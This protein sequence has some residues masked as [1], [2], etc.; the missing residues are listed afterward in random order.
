MIDGNWSSQENISATS[1]DSFVR[2][3]RS[4]AASNIHIIWIDNSAGPWDVYYARRATDGTWSSTENISRSLGDSF[5]FRDIDVDRSGI[6][7]VVS[8]LDDQ[9]VYVRRETDGTWSSPLKISNSSRSTSDEDLALDADGVVHIV[10]RDS[11]DEDIYY[12][13]RSNDGSWSP[14]QNLSNSPY[15]NGTPHIAVEPG[16]AIDVVWWEMAADIPSSIYYAQRD[17]GGV[18]SSPKI[19]AYPDPYG[20][21][22]LQLAIDQSGARHIL[23]HGH[24]GPYS[25]DIFYLGSKPAEESGNS[26]IAQSILV[27]QT[28][29]NPTLSFLYRLGGVFPNNGNRLSVEVDTGIDSTTLFSTTT[30][31]DR[32]MHRWFDVSAWVGETITLTLKVYQNVSRSYTW[33]YLDEVTLGSAH[34]DVWISASGVAALPGEQVVH[35]LTYGNRGGVDTIGVRISATLPSELSFVDASPSPTATTPALVWEAGDLTAGDGPYIIL[36][37]TTVAPAAVP[38][39]TYITSVNIG[40]ALPEIETH[41]NTASAAT[42]V[43][44]R[45]YLPLVTKENSDW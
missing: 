21:Q 26:L 40:A 43:G 36:V 37:T 31:T 15:Y 9:T 42:F 5:W 13:R 35:A 33:A 29:S 3:I 11:S 23:W 39:S 10:W 22:Q 2:Q 17:Y 14:S 16:G 34:P 7:H 30:S 12:A 6:V 20:V 28:M 1:G 4:D 25:N 38:L 44:R 19:I 45:I 18:W 8:N 24:A 32:W 41:N 27:S